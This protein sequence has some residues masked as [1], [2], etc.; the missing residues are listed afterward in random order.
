MNVR[1]SNSFVD[2]KEL[3]V[4]GGDVSE[5]DNRCGSKE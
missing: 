1:K 4:W 2:L 3:V 5:E